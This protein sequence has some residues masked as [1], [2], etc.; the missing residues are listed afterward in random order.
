MAKQANLFLILDNIRSIFN[1]GSI[2]RT[3]DAVGITKIYLCGYTPIPGLASKELRIRNYEKRDHTEEISKTALGA[4]RYV[5][6]EYHKQTVRVI[7][8]LKG[9]G[10]K[11][12]A[13]E[14]ARKSKN[15]FLYKPKLPIALVVGNEIKGLGKTVLNNCDAIVRIPMYGKKESLNVG[16]AAGIAL[17]KLRI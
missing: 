6:W 5:P 15:I 14:Q 13:L 4:E 8:Q 12:V 10:I 1:V 2:F 16:V 17:Y 3:A 7:R 11:V 9:E